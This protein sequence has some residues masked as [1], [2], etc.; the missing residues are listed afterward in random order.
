M[1]KLDTPGRFGHVSHY[2]MQH[3][4]I[5]FDETFCVFRFEADAAF[6]RHLSTAYCGQGYNDR[7]SW[8]GSGSSE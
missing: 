8:N 7:G 2:L 1:C 3:F 6:S 5:L 4:E